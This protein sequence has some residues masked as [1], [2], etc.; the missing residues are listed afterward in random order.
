MLINAYENSTLLDKIKKR[1]KAHKPLRIAFLDIDLTMTGSQKTSNATR[2]KLKQLG[3]AVV[4]V[5]SRT[6]EMLMSSVNYQRSKEYGFDRPEPHFGVSNGKH[7][8]IPPEKIEPSGILN[9]DAIAGSTGTQVMLKQKNKA[10]LAD[11]VFNA[12]LLEDPAIWRERMLSLLDEFNKDGKKAFLELYEDPE[13]YER[14]LTD[15][16][17]PKY[18]IVVTFQSSQHKRMFRSFIH[19]VRLSNPNRLLNLRLTDDSNPQKELFLLCITPKNGSKRRAVDHILDQVCLKAQVKRSSLHVLIAGD[20]IPDLDMGIKAAKG[21]DATFL[22]VGGSRLSHGIICLAKHKPFN[23]ILEKVK[24]SMDALK[25]KGYYRHQFSANR[26]LIVCDEACQG[27]L[28]V[29]SIYWLL[30][31]INNR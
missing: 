25:L 14:G 20:S 28:A 19:H 4:Y 10:Y 15:I 26:N 13:N 16:Y 3:Y 6:E 7:F 12:T 23:E 9:P 17:T 24:E 1:K 22:L 11:T 18:R 21:T 5:T 30:P 29:E 8:Y 31:E 2:R 27:K